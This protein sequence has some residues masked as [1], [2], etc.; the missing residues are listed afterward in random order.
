VTGCVRCACSPVECPW[1]ARSW[2]ASRIPSYEWLH[3]PKHGGQRVTA[4]S[5]RFMSCKSQG[6]PLAAQMGSLWGE[7]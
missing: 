1:V 3:G 2:L 6:R 4:N 5:L 7:S